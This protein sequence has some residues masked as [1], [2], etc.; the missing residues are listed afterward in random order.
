[1]TVKLKA[2][3]AGFA[4]VALS[5]G[6]GLAFREAP[7][8][9][10]A[11]G[12][13]PSVASA[14]SDAAPSITFDAPK[15]AEADAKSGTEIRVPG[16]G[17]LGTLPKLDFGLQLLYSEQ[18]AADGALANQGADVGSDV[19]ESERGLQVRGSITHQF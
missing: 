9:G 7:V 15:S 16:I 18:G 4:L 11:T 12:D 19:K 10:S 1:M 17:R 13:R 5:A 14:E 6:P 3:V 8:A 2:L